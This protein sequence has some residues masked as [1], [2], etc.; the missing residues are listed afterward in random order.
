MAM[1][2]AAKNASSAPVN[3]PRRPRALR[4][5]RRSM[6]SVPQVRELF[7][8][9]VGARSLERA[10]QPAVREQDDPVGPRGGRGVMGD[11][12]DRATVLVDDLA[13][14]REHLAPGAT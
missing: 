13:Q 1:T 14:E 11:H 12:H 5:A 8:D 7:G 4:M 2:D 6:S 3:V 9:R 10:D